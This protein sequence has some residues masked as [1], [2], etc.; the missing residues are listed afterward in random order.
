MLYKTVLFNKG[1][2]I[3]NIFINVQVRFLNDVREKSDLSDAVMKLNKIA[4]LLLSSQ[5]LR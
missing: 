4:K 5:S 1:L 2:H 3:Y